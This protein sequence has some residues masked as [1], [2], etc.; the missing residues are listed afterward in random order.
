MDQNRRRS[1]TP[2]CDPHRSAGRRSSAAGTLN[3]F[4]IE[5]REV[6]PDVYV[7]MWIEPASGNTVTHVDDF[8]NSVAYTNITDLASKGFWRL[9]GTISAMS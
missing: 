9:K 6:R 5:I 8:A 7:V 1:L 3:H 4:E 2:T